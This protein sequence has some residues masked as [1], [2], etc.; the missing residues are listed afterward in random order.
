MTDNNHNEISM[1]YYKIL[2]EILYGEEHLG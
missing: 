2:T 1:K